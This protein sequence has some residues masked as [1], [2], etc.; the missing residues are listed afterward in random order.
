MVGTPLHAG[1]ICHYAFSDSV[2]DRFLGQSH[3]IGLTDMHF[4]PY[5]RYLLADNFLRASGG[6]FDTQ[7]LARLC[8]YASGCAIVQFGSAFAREDYI[9]LATAIAHLI[10]K[11]S[12]QGPGGSYYGI[13]KIVDDDNPTLKLLYPYANFSLH[14]DGVFEDNPV[15]WLMMMQ[16]REQHVTGGKSRL[17]HMADW[18]AYDVFHDDPANQVIRHGLLEKDG[19]YDVFRKFTSLEPSRARILHKRDGMNTVKFVDQYVIPE[20]IAQARF[21]ERFQASV[22]SSPQV[23]ETALP[24]GSMIILN[25]NFWMHGRSA[26]EQHPHLEREQLRQYGCFTEEQ[27][28]GISQHG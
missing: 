28:Q 22:E 25:N 21:I 14:A 15:D 11:P 12:I 26:F 23:Y 3:A 7:L 5:K 18:E 19:R 17:L 10:S 20:T 6:G 4:I 13:S 24:V 2:V 27:L 9:K 8:D 1:R 16:L